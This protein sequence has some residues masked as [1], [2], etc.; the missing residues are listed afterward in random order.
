[1]TK[2]VNLVP[3]NP[4]YYL[5]PPTPKKK[6]MN[7]FASLLVNLEMSTFNTYLKDQQ[8]KLRWEECL[9]NYIPILT[10]YLLKINMCALEVL[11]ISSKLIRSQKM[12]NK[13]LNTTN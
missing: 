7:V 4:W 3:T 13:K 1:M 8:R 5:T 6:M 11:K 2:L 10:T 9:E 12:K